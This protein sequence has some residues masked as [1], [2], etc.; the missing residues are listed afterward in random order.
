MEYLDE[1]IWYLSLPI[2]VWVAYRFV[3]INLN[4]FDKQLKDN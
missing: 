1:I 2:M 3:L 4:Q